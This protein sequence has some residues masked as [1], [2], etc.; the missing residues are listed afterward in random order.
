MGDASDLTPKDEQNFFMDACRVFISREGSN[1]DS[2]VS[3]LILSR[4]NAY[5]P[6]MTKD[7]A[8]RLFGS[9]TALARAIGVSPQAVYQWPT[10]LSRNLED[11]VCAAL[12][13]QNR[14]IPNI[15]RTDRAA[16]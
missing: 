5:N 14:P 1:R 6:A 4:K 13:R 11:R 10:I 16:P 12:A 9:G 15:L 3:R 2:H 8:I 7:E